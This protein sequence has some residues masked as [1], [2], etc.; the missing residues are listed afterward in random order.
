MAKPLFDDEEDL[1]SSFETPKDTNDILNDLQNKKYENYFKTRGKLE[2]PSDLSKLGEVR[3]DEASRRYSANN[4]NPSSGII[5]RG[6]PEVEAAQGVRPFS[7]KSISDTGFVTKGPAYSTQDSKL[8]ALKRFAEQQGR[9]KIESNRFEMQ[10]S[11]SSS[12]VTPEDVKTQFKVDKNAFQMR[13]GPSTKPEGLSFD[14]MKEAFKKNRAGRLSVKN[15]PN[16]SSELE[17]LEPMYQNLFKELGRK[18]TFEEMVDVMAKPMV[19]GSEKILGG[20]A[21]VLSSKPAQVIGR[22][23]AAPVAAYLE[24]KEGLENLKKG[25]YTDASANALNL[26]S[27]IATAAGSELALP[28][29]AG[30]LAVKGGHELGKQQASLADRGIYTDP[31]TGMTTSEEEMNHTDNSIQKSLKSSGGKPLS[32][33]ELDNLSN[34]DQIKKEEEFKAYEDA[35][36]TSR[37]TKP[38]LTEGQHEMNALR[39]VRQLREKRQL[40]LTGDNPLTKIGD[41]FS[42]MFKESPERAEE[43]KR[44]AREEFNRANDVRKSMGLPLRAMPKEYEAIDLTPHVPTEEDN[45]KYQFTSKQ[46]ASTPAKSSGLN[47]QGTEEENLGKTLEDLK[48][49]DY[50]NDIEDLTDE[51]L[52]NLAKGRGEKRNISYMG[53]APEGFKRPEIKDVKSE[54][55][56]VAKRV[57]LNPAIFLGQIDQESSFNPLAVSSTGAKGLGQMFPDAFIDAKKMDKEGLL[58]NVSYHDLIN[59]TNW[60][61]QLYA[62]ALYNKWIDKY[63][64]K[65]AGDEARLKWYSDGGDEEKAKRNGTDPSE[66]SNSVLRRAKKYEKELAEEESQT[67]NRSPADVQDEE[68][69]DQIPEVN[70]RTSIS[71]IDKLK[72]I[73]NFLEGKSEQGQ[74]PLQYGPYAN[75]DVGRD[76]FSRGMKSSNRLMALKDQYEKLKSETL[77]PS[78]GQPKSPEETPP[79]GQEPPSGEQKNIELKLAEDAAKEQAAKEKAVGGAPAANTEAP[80]SPEQK[81]IANSLAMAKMGQDDVRGDL[82]RAQQAQAQNQFYAN[83]GRSLTQ[84]ATGAAGIGG[85]VAAKLPDMGTFESLE[86]QAGQPVEAFKQ[87]L[88]SRKEDPNS[89]VSKTMRD[90]LGEDLKKAGIKVDLSGMSYNQLKDVY[91]NVSRM[92]ERLDYAKIKT[93]EKK[94]SDEEKQEIKDRNKTIDR[95]DKANKLLT[96][97]LGRGSSFGAD[98]RAL[99]ATQNIKALL[100]GR[101]LNDLNTQEVYEV[102]KSLDKVISQGATTISGTKSLTPETARSWVSKK[103]EFITNQRKG[104]G[105]ESFIKQF[106]NNLDREEKATEGRIKKTQRKILSSLSDLKEKDPEK[107]ELM[108]KEHGLPTNPFEDD[109]NEV[110]SKSID[111]FAKAHNIKRDE[112]IKVLKKAGKI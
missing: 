15:T 20:A 109:Y 40:E 47:D 84:V 74:G 58:K 104:A 33:D 73:K 87:Q 100:K 88:E 3:L 70:D 10:G 99:A 66:Y 90:L 111:D 49:F 91:P 67:P 79:S 39:A 21:K 4:P 76:L 13:E 27:A 12:G 105:A 80:M 112:A 7:P 8:E 78:A 71:K 101:D 81:S 1:S 17:L 75:T 64:T 37:V 92:A 46:L 42:N 30:G 19:S 54:A 56:N 2:T 31:T 5:Q 6:S 28:L 22:G 96:A 57:G 44:L 72:S 14:E 60:K 50:K 83:L 48:R 23:V 24:G 93:A 53:E 107:W 97:E 110:T 94:E 16:V 65:G 103:L 82:L 63:M 43:R 34:P 106:Q 108:M 61:A 32:E 95:F 68:D 45:K 9:N 69:E 102:A 29:A 55:V 26:G 77:G 89:E 35:L 41:A 52:Q 86:K 38:N 59:P 25:E 36:A 85:R 18:P 98:A 62:S 51:D 11:P